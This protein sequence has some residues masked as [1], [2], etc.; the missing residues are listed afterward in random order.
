MAEHEPAV[1]VDLQSSTVLLDSAPRDRS[2]TERASQR[3]CASETLMED[4]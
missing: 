1:D 3:N 4:S 2:G